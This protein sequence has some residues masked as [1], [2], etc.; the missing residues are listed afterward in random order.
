[1]IENIKLQEKRISSCKSWVR[2]FASLFYNMAGAKRNE[3][4]T[5]F[6]LVHT[7]GSKLFIK[8]M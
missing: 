7:A 4:T 6:E 3:A 1:M 5:I 8:Q 2:D